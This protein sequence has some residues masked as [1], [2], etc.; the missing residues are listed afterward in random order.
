[1]GVGPDLKS[2]RNLDI[3]SLDKLIFLVFS[4][5]QFLGE[6][7]LKP[8]LLDGMQQLFNSTLSI[9][10]THIVVTG[11]GGDTSGT[12][13]FYNSNNGAARY[14]VVNGN[15]G[16]DQLASTTYAQGWTHIPAGTISGGLDGNVIFAYLFYNASTGTAQFYQLNA[17]GDIIQLSNT[18]FAKGWSKIIWQAFP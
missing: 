10:W 18:T 8:N 6:E 15:G 12:M 3:S 9:G 14:V 4:L 13:L 16:I 17:P 1:M 7:V 2:S 11:T 5:V